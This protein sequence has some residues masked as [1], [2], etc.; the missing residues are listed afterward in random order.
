MFTYVLLV[1]ARDKKVVCIYKHVSTNMT[2]HNTLSTAII[3]SLTVNVL[4][5]VLFA[6]LFVY[7]YNFGH[8]N[9]NSQVWLLIQILQ[10]AKLKN[11]VT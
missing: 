10:F 1:N 4:K 3:S 9:M 8:K 11:P 2:N 7:A 5:S 6:C